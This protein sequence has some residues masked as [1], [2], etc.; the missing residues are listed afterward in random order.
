ML[1]SEN[2]EFKVLH[3]EHKILKAKMDKI[4][5]KLHLTPE[6]ELEKKNIQKQKLA[7]KDS[8]AKMIRD[9][10]ATNA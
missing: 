8:M 2:E 1:E 6:E 7:K 10:K 9:Y 5:S 3:E 4:K